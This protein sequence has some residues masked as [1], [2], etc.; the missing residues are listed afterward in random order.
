MKRI[1]VLLLII[2]GLYIIFNKNFEFDWFKAGSSNEATASVSNHTRNINVD[3]GSGNTS[4]IPDDRKDVKAVY[5]GKEKLTVKEN[6]D[7]V[8]VSLKHK[9]FDWF[10]WGPFSRHNELK[11]YVPKT[12]HSTMAIHLGSG[13]ISFSGQ[14]KDHP[15]KLEEL[16]LEIGSGNMNLKNMEIDRFKHEGASGNVK[17]DTLTTNTG[18]I[19]LSSGNLNIKHYTGAV[20]ADVSSGKLNLQMEQLT[21]SVDINV[22]SGNVN[23]DLP[24]KADFTLKGDVKSG[25]IRCDLPL[26]SKESSH[27]SI[28]GIHGSGKYK[29]DLSV[30]SG[31]VNIK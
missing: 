29:V 31:F 3:V 19:E 20:K 15:V 28:K 10:N 6:G 9:W 4:I 21:D 8:E 17:I 7:T 27:K 26:E 25:N 13:N 2:T 23:L 16:A 14:S 5:N 1:L 24:D 18:S 30:S 11:I 22:S 12:Y